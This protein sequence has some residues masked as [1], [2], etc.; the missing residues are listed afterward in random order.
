MFRP[1]KGK[2]GLAQ[3][4]FHTC[5][6]LLSKSVV[7][8]NIKEG[9]IVLSSKNASSFQ[10][11]GR[12]NP[13]KAVFIC[14]CH[15]KTFPGWKEF[16]FFRRYLKTAY[17]NKRKTWLLQVTSSYP[18]MNMFL[19]KAWAQNWVSREPLWGLIALP[20]H[21]PSWVLMLTADTR[22]HCVYS[23]VRK[24]ISEAWQLLVLKLLW[25]KQKPFCCV[26]R[27]PLYLWFRNCF[28]NEV[29]F[30]TREFHDCPC[31][32]VCVHFL[33][34]EENVW[35]YL[36]WKESWVLTSVKMLAS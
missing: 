10:L 7:W 11:T 34:A 19:I 21:P 12:T 18:V 8:R 20:R 28:I 6:S 33:T 35:T 13:L 14:S 16:F 2:P 27:P 5:F 1:R 15:W 26:P 23:A 31:C 32:S 24:V 29:S 3:R 22:G 9:H 36:L 30:F 17:P 25:G 4:V